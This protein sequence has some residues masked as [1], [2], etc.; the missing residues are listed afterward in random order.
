METYRFFS[1]QLSRIQFDKGLLKSVKK[2]VQIH[3]DVLLFEIK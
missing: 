1:A 3:I 2:Y